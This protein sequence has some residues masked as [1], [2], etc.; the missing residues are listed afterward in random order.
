MALG[1]DP[2][3]YTNFNTW[4][5]MLGNPVRRPGTGLWNAWWDNNP[6]FDF[7]ANQYGGW[8]IPE[9]WGEQFEGSVIVAGVLVD[10]DIFRAETFYPTPPAPP[11]PA[12]IYVEV[13]TGGTSSVSFD[14]KLWTLSA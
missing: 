9:V 3:V 14:P 10:L 4:V 8:Q 5:Y 1:K 13:R 2:D 7:A 11:A 6:D 12:P